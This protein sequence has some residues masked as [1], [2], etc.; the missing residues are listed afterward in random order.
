[1]RIG[2]GVDLMSV[3][4]FARVA[5]HPRYREIVFT[6]AELAQADDLGEARR[7]ERLA[8][9]FC[10][11]EA[12]CK[13]LGRGFLQ[14]LR[15]RDI[16]IISDKWGA[17]RVTLHG[18]ARRTAQQAG[19]TDIALALTHQADLVV[20]VAAA[21][22]IPPNHHDKEPGMEYII[23]TEQDRLDDI[24]RIA[25]DLFSVTAAEVAAAQSFIDDLGA[26]S[27][28]VIDLLT[29]LERNY[30][31]RIPDSDMLRMVDLGS[32]YEVVAEHAGW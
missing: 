10:A 30:D 15:W 22:Q 14:G 4:R 6:G 29:R 13:L 17:P 20:A 26:D 5:V 7:V 16:E 24:A 19:L 11:K 25:A 12:T 32:T 2:I 31:I 23:A 8:G 1:M 3:S 28:L 9:R 18:G 27:L 21:A